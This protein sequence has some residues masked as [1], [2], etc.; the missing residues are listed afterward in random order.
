M[1]VSWST[2]FLEIVNFLILIWILKHFFYRPVLEVIARRRAAVEKIL[3]DAKAMQ[4]AAEALKAQ[5]ENR[6]G[7]WEKERQAAH[8][9]LDKEIAA[10]SARRLAVLQSALEQEREKARVLAARDA[11]A[12]RIRTEQAALAHATQFATRLLSAVAGPETERRLLE[13]LLKELPSL[14]PEAKDRLNTAAKSAD[15]ARVVSAFPLDEASRQV[16]EHSL[17]ALLERVP[18]FAYEEDKELLAGARITIGDWALR[19]NLRDELGAFAE[20][21]DER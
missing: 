19:A 14:P 10:E 2:F 5:Y 6:L 20:F 21:S 11:E 1:E 18:P 9:T 16:L 17:A 7:Q 3:A 13:L 8:E 15:A 4:T 12:A